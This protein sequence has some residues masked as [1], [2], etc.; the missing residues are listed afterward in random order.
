MH[1]DKGADSYVWWTWTVRIRTIAMTPFQCVL[2]GITEE[3]IYQLIAK[4]ALHLNELGLSN[5]RIAELLN[6]NDK[7]VAKAIRWAQKNSVN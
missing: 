4:K 2:T 3:P 6:V 7:T 1:A 5:Y